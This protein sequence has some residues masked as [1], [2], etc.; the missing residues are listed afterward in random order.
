[1]KNRQVILIIEVPSYWQSPQ[2]LEPLQVGH[3]SA[4]FL[5]RRGL[6]PS[7]V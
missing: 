3:V 6:H 2:Q 7:L 1:M 5:H 4:C